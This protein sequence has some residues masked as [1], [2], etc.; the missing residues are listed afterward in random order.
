MMGCARS[1][2]PEALSPGLLA[3]LSLFV[4]DHTVRAGGTSDAGD[5]V[6]ISLVSLGVGMSAFRTNYGSACL[7]PWVERLTCCR[8]PRHSAQ[9]GPGSFHLGPVGPRRRAVGHTTS[10]AL[11]SPFAP[12]GNVY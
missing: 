12:V 7:R 2:P 5:S 6:M 11:W 10:T 1:S 4:A 9:D 3:C 8:M